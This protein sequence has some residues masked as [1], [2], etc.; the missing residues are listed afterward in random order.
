VTNSTWHLV[1]T[2]EERPFAP[3]YPTDFVSLAF[4]HVNGILYYPLLLEGKLTLWK[5]SVSDPRWKRVYSDHTELYGVSNGP[6]PA[7]AMV[8]VDSPRVLINVFQDLM[9]DVNVGA[10]QKRRCFHSQNL[11]RFFFSFSPLQRA[12]RLLFSIFLL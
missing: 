12:E 1:S 2:I 11:E 3:I 5:L 4:D 6:V 9:W 8:W 10:Y 7:A